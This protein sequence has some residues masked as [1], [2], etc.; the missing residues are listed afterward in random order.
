M[1][2]VSLFFDLHFFNFFFQKVKG[3]N[4]QKN[5]VVRRI[6]FNFAALNL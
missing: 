1:S 5:F 3:K 4:M 6:F 2:L